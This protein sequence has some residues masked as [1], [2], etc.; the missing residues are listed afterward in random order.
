[1]KTVIEDDAA[2]SGST[3]IDCTNLPT[4]IGQSFGPGAEEEVAALLQRIN[5]LIEDVQG[6]E[7]RIQQ[8]A[9][10]RQQTDSALAGEI[11]GALSYI[12]QMKLTIDQQIQALIELLN[13]LK[14]V[15]PKVVMA[16]VATGSGSV[17]RPA[18]ST[19][20]FT[21]TRYTILITPEG[22]HEGWEIGRSTDHFTINA[23]NRSGTSVGMNTTTSG[24]VPSQAKTFAYPGINK[25]P[26]VSMPMPGTTLG[27]P[28]YFNTNDE[29]S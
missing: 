1:M 11:G 17:Q 10:V 2:G 7:Q 9:T 24:V 12:Q 15:F 14:G 6:M 21:D 18:G 8:E 29:P 28:N 16:G 20:D 25:A 26:L 4:I 22:A 3:Q 27:N 23:W 19:I 5:D 13:N